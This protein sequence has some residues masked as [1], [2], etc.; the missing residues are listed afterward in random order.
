V[1]A[2]APA[3]AFED[4][5]RRLLVEYGL[6]ADERM[7]KLADPP[8]SVH[9]LQ[10]G[11][12]E[13]LLL[14]HGSGMSAATWASLMAHLPD[15]RIIALDLPGFGLSDD[16]DY[17]GRSLRS[18][19]VAQLR[20]VLDALGL[21]RAPIVGTSLGAMWAL[22][23]ALDEPARVSGVA[24]LG[25]PAV[26]FPGVHADFFFRV[27]TVPGLGGLVARAP[28]PPSTAATRRAIGRAL[29]RHARDRMPDVFFELVRAG[30]RMPGWPQAMWSHLNLAFRSG[31][32]RAENV[33][34][35]EELR[36]ITAPVM[37]IWGDADVYGGPELAAHAL[38]VMPNAR[39]TAMP[40]GHAP[41]LDDPGRCAAVITEIA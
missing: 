9:I 39:L 26:V 2:P 21:V 22:C 8:L 20:S 16:Y 3:T 23:L 37:L 19:A 38:R 32:Q 27:M 7:V 6:V 15:R 36:R 14:V 17:R 34:S 13:P 28:A 24:G 10:I 40:G 29:G 33:L 31:R 30:M 12:G 25:V 5:Q 18:H 35:D 4:A 1:N 41:F 11:A